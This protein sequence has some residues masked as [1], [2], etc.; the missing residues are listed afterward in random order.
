[1]AF[2]GVN[3]GVITATEPMLDHTRGRMSGRA[4][5]QSTSLQVLVV[6]ATATSACA[7]SLFAPTATQDEWS[8]LIYADQINSGQVPNRD[9][10]TPYGPGTFWPISLAFL[11]SPEPSVFSARAVAIFYHAA[12]ALGVWGLCRNAGRTVAVTAG[13]FSGLLAAGLL[14][15][16]YGW[17][18]A[19]S[20]VLWSIVAAERRRFLLCGALAAW[21]CTV[22]PEFVVLVIALMCVLIRSKI[23]LTRASTGFAIA[24]LPL[25]WHLIAAGSDL[26]QNV[27]LDRVTAAT[28]FPFPPSSPMLRAQLALVLAAILVLIV[29]AATTKRRMEVVRA[30]LAIGILPQ[31]LQRT[32]SE[33]IAFVGIAVIPL[34]VA[35][36]LLRVRGALNNS[37]RHRLS[38]LAPAMATAVAAAS[39]LMAFVAPRG[40]ILT[41]HD[42]KVVMQDEDVARETAAVADAIETVGQTYK[43]PVLIGTDNMSRAAIIETGYYFLLPEFIPDA[44]YLEL[45]PGVSERRGSR[46]ADDLEKATVLA[47]SPFSGQRYRFLYPYLPMGD[48]ELNSYVAENFCLVDRSSSLS[49]YAR[50]KTT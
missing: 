31:A 10:F 30:V 45:A 40:V 7:W 14:A 4:S 35:V 29:H 36:V 49:F 17:M 37:A 34:A 18:L 21:A 13:V 6:V 22:R 48:S 8:L 9:F 1:M 20:S 43:S 38:R 19:L 2:T 26:V 15:I 47:L 41:Y 12:V 24:A 5:R 33:H 32:D 25:I 23:D 50:C 3:F 11:A 42:R 27:F 44:Y 39:L 16:P 46:L 28:R